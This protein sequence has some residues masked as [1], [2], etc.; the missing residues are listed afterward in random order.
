[1]VADLAV[2][3][4]ASFETPSLPGQQFAG[5]VDFVQPLVNMAS[6]TIGVRVVLPNAEGILR[7]GLFG[8]VQLTASPGDETVVIP[9]S[10][11]IDSGLRQL[12]LVQVAPGRFE[13]RDVRL[14]RRAGDRVAVL[15]GVRSGEEVVVSA[16]FLIDA[17]S[18]L[19]SALQGLSTVGGGDDEVV[20]ESAPDG[21]ATPEE[22][23]AGHAMPEP[24]PQEDPH[25]GHGKEH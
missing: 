17:E 6:R 3:D 13:P 12:V 14:G 7:P 5:T 2:G 19:T 20:P 22:D 1:M 11:V 16:N 9:R 25:A 15:E 8:D 18:N 21:Q 23:H 4:A 10:A 24:E